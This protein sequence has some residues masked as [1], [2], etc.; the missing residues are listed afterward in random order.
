MKPKMLIC[1][2]G[3]RTS[4]YMTYRL[5][6]EYADQYEIVV[7]FANTGQE[8][9]ATLRFVNACDEQLGFNVIWL[10]A[11]PVMGKRARTGWKRVDYTTASRTGV[12]YEGVIQKYGLP[13]Q[14]FLHCTR[15]L[16][17]LPIHGYLWDELGW[18]K[19]GYITAIGMRADEPKRT[20]SKKPDRQTKQNKVFPLAHW[21]PTTKEDVLDFWADMPFDLEIPEHRGNCTWCYKKSQA[22]LRRVWQEK[23]GDFAFPLLME[24][25]YGEINAPEGEIRKMFR[26][27][28]STSQLIAM[29]EETGPT[30]EPERTSAPGSCD[31]EC[32]PFGEYDD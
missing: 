11:V 15:E 13:N 12:P 4:A 29:F 23:K 19:G 24:R 7:I 21:W 25:M 16:K 14:N 22:K 9:D 17:E 1:F 8:D 30:D 31:E 28:L 6:H 18:E 2:S 32:N 5:L 10:E 3:G 26:G 27:N 20:T